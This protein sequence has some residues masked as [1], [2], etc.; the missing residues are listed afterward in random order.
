MPS[1]E[2][3]DKSGL[4]LSTTKNDTLKMAAFMNAALYYGEQNWDSAYKYASKGLLLAKKIK[5]PLWESWFLIRKGY[6]LQKNRSYNEAQESFSNA[7]AA[8]EKNHDGKNIWGLNYFTNYNEAGKVRS[9]LLAST[10][11]NI[12]LLNGVVGEFNKCRRNYNKSIEI[13][14]ISSDNV[15]LAAA[16]ANLTNFYI[17][18]GRL[19]TAIINADSSLYYLHS[20]GFGELNPF[21]YKFYKAIALKNKGRIYLKKQ[22]SDSAAIFLTEARQYCT[23]DNLNTVLTNI[24]LSLTDLYFSKGQFDTA[25]LYA[26]ESLKASHL[27]NSGNS[28]STNRSYNFLYKIYREKKENDSVIKYL[29][30][31]KISGD[32]LLFFEQDEIR[33]YQNE[34]DRKINELQRLEI[35][36]QQQRNYG[37][38]GTVILALAITGIFI[39]QRNRIKMGKKLS[40]DL[41]L[42]ILPKETAEEIKA[43]GTAKQKALI[44][45]Q[46]CLQI[47][48]TLLSPVKN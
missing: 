4:L 37:L 6:A 9:Y 22:K 34:N 27:L 5:Q 14:K 13:A 43:T 41:L 42:N 2:Q 21:V 24:N 36:K 31:A 3:F 23:E 17:S 11:L 28:F 20:K 48:K 18:A 45:Q 35:K 46:Y 19:D 10:Y 7:L 40:D 33:K 44:R 26:Y 25:L 1:K 38:A 29:E 30:L 8:A 32:S 16:Y 47:L 12:A 39:K 15:G